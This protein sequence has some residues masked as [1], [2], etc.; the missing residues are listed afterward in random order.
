[1]FNRDAGS[2]TGSFG[3]LARGIRYEFFK[4]KPALRIGRVEEVLPLHENHYL[5]KRGGPVF[6]DGLL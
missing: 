6:D 5:A 3:A 2:D 4:F 1:M